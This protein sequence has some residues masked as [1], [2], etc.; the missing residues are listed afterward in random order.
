MKA[1]TVTEEPRVGHGGLS[2]ARRE[3]KRGGIGESRD[4]FE[5]GV[6]PAVSE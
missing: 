4:E 1:T 3:V 6:A 5:G 2:W